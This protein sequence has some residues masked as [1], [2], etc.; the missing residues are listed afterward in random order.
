[1]ALRRA[2]SPTKDARSA[3][4]TLPNA[5]RC[6]GSFWKEVQDPRMRAR[7]PST[8]SSRSGA[9]AA[10]AAATSTPCG[11]RRALR[12][13]A[14]A[15]K[16]RRGE[17]PPWQQRSTEH[18]PL[19]ATRPWTTCARAPAV[20]VSGRA[21]RL[22]LAS[23]PDL[24]STFISVWTMVYWSCARINQTVG[25]P[26]NQNYCIPLSYTTLPYHCSN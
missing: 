8:R 21:L 25:G 14:A 24:P 18:A 3:V 10:R 4:I 5:N 26:K 2:G 20:A 7:S 13:R 9:L 17:N 6:F 1:M 12:N 16:S 11:R 22:S 15:G 23:H 19:R